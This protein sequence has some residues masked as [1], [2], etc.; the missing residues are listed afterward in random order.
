MKILNATRSA[1]SIMLDNND[2]ITIQPGEFSITFLASKNAICAA[3]SLGTPSEVGI[4][5][6][7]TWEQGVANQIT[8]AAPYLYL[9]EDEAKAKLLDPTIDY[10]SS[11]ADTQ[12]SNLRESVAD[13]ELKIK[14][15][16]DQI[17]VKD[18]KIAELEAKGNDADYQTQKIKL[19]Q[20][21]KQVSEL[22][23]KYKMTTSELEG[24]KN[25]NAQLQTTIGTLN[26]EKKS[27]S[28]KVEVIGNQLRDANAQ[29]DEAN[30]K[31]E[32]L[33]SDLSEANERI[34]SMKAKFNEA[35]EKFKI[36]L[37]EN[38]QWIKLP[39]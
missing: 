12:L 23:E 15:L 7:G 21:E 33:L 36:S 18:S 28:D 19:D 22:T 35:C 30:A 27:L 4:V 8:G 39:E 11:M 24:V 25:T 34:E 16:K 37:D 1:I 14:D 10:K 5:L 31:S 32:T 29:L 38:G 2:L 3:L 13:Y 17:I 26:V 20:A 9:S 6:G